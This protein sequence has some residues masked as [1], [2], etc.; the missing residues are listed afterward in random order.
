[1]PKAP[2]QLPK[3]PIRT[4]GSARKDTFRA[5]FLLVSRIELETANRRMTSLLGA[6]AAKE[7][8]HPSAL[9]GVQLMRASRPIPRTQ[10][11]YQP[12]IVIVGQGRKRGYLGDRVFT[13]DAH[14]YLVLSVPL[15]SFGE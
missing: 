14:N 1:M 4:I 11:L 9:E 5:T 13:Y 3:P 15:P 2:Q 10:V 7:G 8:M 6:L 12:G